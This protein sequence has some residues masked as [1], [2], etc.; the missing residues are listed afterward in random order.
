MK[1]KAN[2]ESP[3]HSPPEIPSIKYVE[4]NTETVSENLRDDGEQQL[5]RVNRIIE[6][7]TMQKS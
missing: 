1:E 4:W 6:T 3:T 2:D 5:Q 7:I